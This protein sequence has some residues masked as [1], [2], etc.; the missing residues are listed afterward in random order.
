MNLA[1]YTF[2]YVEND[3]DSRQ[4]IEML[5]EFKIGK[6]ALY[7]FEDSQNFVE[8]VNALPT[9]PD[10]FLL[11]I[12]VDPLNGYQM[13]TNLRNV[14][15]YN[16]KLIIAVTASVTTDDVEKLQQASFD[17]LIG[18][19]INKHEFPHLLESIISGEEIWY[20]P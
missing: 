1:D 15:Q 16:D 4:I 7:I 12:H 2:L 5:F 11:D 3:L 17:G 10:V 6:P 13:I 14:P 18:K 19:P 9:I 8:R 20:V